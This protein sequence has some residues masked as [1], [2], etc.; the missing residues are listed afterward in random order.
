[1][2]Q[3]KNLV[4]NFKKK[5]QVKW[6]LIS[7]MITVLFM[8][9]HEIIHFVLGTFCIYVN[10]PMKSFLKISVLNFL[11]PSTDMA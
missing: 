7:V 6:F 4:N 5:L 1:M 8:K 2:K 10:R 9:N 11:A 3:L